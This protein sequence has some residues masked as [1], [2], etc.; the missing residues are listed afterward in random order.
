MTNEVDAVNRQFRKLKK[1]KDG[2]T[3]QK[4]ILK[5]L[6]AGILKTPECWTHPI[7]NWNLTQS[8]LALHF[9]GR[10]DKHPALRSFADTELGT[11]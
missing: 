6:Y 3:N 11:P 8:R 1:T 2:F 5:L 10:L 9:D 4:N 7:Q